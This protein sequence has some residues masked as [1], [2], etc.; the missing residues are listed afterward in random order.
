MGVSSFEETGL[1]WNKKVNKRPRVLYSQ[2]VS[3]TCGLCALHKNNLYI[4]A[5]V[6]YI[7]ILVTNNSLYTQPFHTCHLFNVRIS[8]LVHNDDPSYPFSSLKTS[9]MSKRALL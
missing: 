3:P 9:I 5:S 8:H 7:Q 2:L 1:W 6:P 4:M